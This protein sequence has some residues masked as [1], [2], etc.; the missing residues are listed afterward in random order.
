MPIRHN[1]ILS[2]LLLP[3]SAQEPQIDE[4]N[5]GAELAPSPTGEV[6]YLGD[7]IL[8]E[9][10]EVL[11]LLTE[12][13]D[14]TTADAAAEPLR[15]RLKSLDNQVRMLEKLPFSDEQDART[16][17]SDMTA[18]KH[19]SQ[20]V[21]EIIRRLQDV[22]AYGSQALM[23]VFE[24]Y[25]FGKEPASVLRSDDIPHSQLCNQLADEIEDAL[26]TLRKIQDEVSA[27]DGANT[28]EDLLHKIERTH[29]LLTQLAAPRTDEQCEALESAR[30]RMRHICAEIRKVHDS[31][32]LNQFF[33]EPRLDDIL[34]RLIRATVL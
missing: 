25:K 28:A 11:K 22:G 8:N 17:H 12:I 20:A 32:R 31:L 4:K 2:F 13:S 19:L 9:A 34:D 23:N 16:I 7:Q 29:D 26:Y 6:Q 1:I 10:R 14:R 3:A 24:Q 27:R 5:Q 18:L 21:L 33:K 15:E 30:A